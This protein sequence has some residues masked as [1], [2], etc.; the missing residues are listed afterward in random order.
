MTLAAPYLAA[1]WAMAST[2]SPSTAT[3]H[4]AERLRAISKP[5]LIATSVD[6]GK[7][8]CMILGKN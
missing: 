8:S 7:C 1:V 4:C 6:L 5:A 3:T 2:L